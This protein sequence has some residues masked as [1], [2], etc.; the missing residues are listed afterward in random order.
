MSNEAEK[1]ILGNKYHYDHGVMFREMPEKDAV[2]VVVQTKPNLPNETI[3]IPKS[4]CRW[5]VNSK[6]GDVHIY[7]Q[8][9]WYDKN[10]GKFEH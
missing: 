5:D 7:I 1:Y 4:V 6:T 9:W 3:W 10:E 8:E 2:R